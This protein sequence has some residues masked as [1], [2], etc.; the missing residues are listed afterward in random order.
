MLSKII[1]TIIKSEHKSWNFKVSDFY[2]HV[3]IKNET[4]LN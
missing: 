1:I 2:K 3:K 4:K